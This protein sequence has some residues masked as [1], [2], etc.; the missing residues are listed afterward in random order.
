[1]G[2][3]RHVIN[4]QI[5]AVNCSPLLTRN[6]KLDDRKQQSQYISII[7]TE[8]NVAVKEKATKTVEAFH[9]AE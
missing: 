5:P 8:T 6:P 4:K 3:M 9:A 7:A 1:M 2:Y